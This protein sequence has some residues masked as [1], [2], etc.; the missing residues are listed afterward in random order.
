[1]PILVQL[2]RWFSFFF[3]ISV[4]PPEEERKWAVYLAC[5]LGVMM[6]VGIGAV[7]L[8]FKFGA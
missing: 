4:P 1:M 2:L 7:V 8:L 5:V 6:A 3:G